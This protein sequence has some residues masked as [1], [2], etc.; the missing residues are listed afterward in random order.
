[1]DGG[2]TNSHTS[3]MQELSARSALDHLLAAQRIRRRAH[4][5]DMLTR[6]LVRAQMRS[7]HVWAL[8]RMGRRNALLVL[9]RH[10][11]P[12]PIVGI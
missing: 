4:A 12:T 10:H 7:M 3:R 1:M 2:W 6:S 11:T 9:Q 8:W 5:A